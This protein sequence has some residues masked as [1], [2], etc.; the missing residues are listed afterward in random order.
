MTTTAPTA[1]AIAPARIPTSSTAPR[2]LVPDA[3]AAPSTPNVAPRE[4]F[5][6]TLR[7]DPTSETAPSVAHAG[8]EPL[9]QPGE[10]TACAPASSRATVPLSY[11]TPSMVTA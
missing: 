8:P 7:V 2:E 5:P 3:G 10:A 1:R 6:D 4:P 11:G 9:P